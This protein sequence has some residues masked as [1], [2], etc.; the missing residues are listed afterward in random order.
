MATRSKIKPSQVKAVDKET[1]ELK[2]ENK[3]LLNIITTLTKKNISDPNLDLFIGVLKN[4]IDKVK[5]ALNK[6]ANPN[7]TDR[8]IL[9]RYSY[10]IKEDDNLK[11]MLVEYLAAT[12]KPK[13]EEESGKREEEAKLLLSLLESLTK[14][15]ISDPNLDL[16]IGVLKNDIDKVKEALNKG[17]N[18]NITDASLIK[19]YANLLEK[20][21][22]ESFKKY[23]QI[24]G[25]PI[26]TR[27]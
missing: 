13:S 20:E 14:K 25:I 12:E 18:P 6:G 3:L 22:P 8:E 1:T 21:N 27:K 16:F 4:D 2:N 7:I 5:E 23:C 15:N 19:Y 24:K 26:N 17:A 9:S 11:K 10:V